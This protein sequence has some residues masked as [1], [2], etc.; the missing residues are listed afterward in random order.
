[1]WNV[2]PDGEEG[3]SNWERLEST[4]GNSQNRI[5]IYVLPASSISTPWTSQNQSAHVSSLVGPVASPMR[6]HPISRLP[7]ALPKPS[8]QGLAQLREVVSQWRWGLQWGLQDCW[9]GGELRPFPSLKVHRRG[10]TVNLAPSPRCKNFSPRTHALMIND[11][12]DCCQASAVWSMG[13]KDDTSNLDKPP[14]GGFDF[15]FCHSGDAKIDWFNVGNT[16]RLRMLTY[17]FVGG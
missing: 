9:S 16:D 14:L 8:R 3:R 12:D 7:S 1:M 6:S 5:L 4:C 2:Q 10:P 15:D 17:S 11:F 13:E